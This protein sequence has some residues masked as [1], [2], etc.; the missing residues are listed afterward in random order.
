[1]YELAPYQFS[2]V[3]GLL[4]SDGWISFAETKTQA[5]LGLT[6]SL[7]KFE[8][9]WNVFVALSHYCA[10]LPTF[11]TRIR[12][13]KLLYSLTFQTRSLSC[14]SKIHQLFIENGV[15]IIPQDIFNMLDPVA[16]A[17]WIQGDGKFVVSGGLRLCTD[18][19][20]IQDVV[21]LM[22]VLMVRYELKCTLHQSKEGQY[23]IFIS[24]KIYG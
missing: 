5:R 17:H 24:K 18:S 19:Y 15:K 9:F 2:I 4:L 8:Y 3:V 6:Q 14:F 23:Q 21:R 13:S 20:T 11:R 16:L 10:G 12:N 1:M 7:D 22:N